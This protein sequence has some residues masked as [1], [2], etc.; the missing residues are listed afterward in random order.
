[1]F[2]L[3]FVVLAAGVIAGM[4]TV[5]IHI[6]DRLRSYGI[7]VGARPPQFAAVLGVVNP[8]PTRKPASPTPTKK[9]IV[10]ITPTPTI[11][12][13]PEQCRADC[14]SVACPTGLTC[15]AIADDEGYYTYTCLNP[16]CTPNSQNELCQCA[17]P[18]P[19]PTVTPK[20]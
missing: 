5:M 1:M 19:T 12:I 11:F 15:T 10:R 16:N 4:F 3:P 7:L 2:F 13:A 20:R 6:D 18:S 17:T 8:T 14:T 9:V